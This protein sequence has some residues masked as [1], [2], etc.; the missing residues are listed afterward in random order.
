MPKGKGGRNKNNINRNAKITLEKPLNNPRKKNPETHN[1]TTTKNP[2]VM[3]GI[4]EGVNREN[5]K[6]NNDFSK[7]ELADMEINEGMEGKDEE[8]EIRRVIKKA[9]NTDKSAIA[10]VTQQQDVGS[11]IPSRKILNMRKTPKVRQPHIDQ[12]SLGEVRYK[13][14]KQDITNG[15]QHTLE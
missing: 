1:P 9:K 12:P 8:G 13:M 10:I 7:N 2:Y 15:K 4:L 6:Y 5:V 3:L 11:K 14:T